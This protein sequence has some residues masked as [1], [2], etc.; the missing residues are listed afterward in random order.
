MSAAVRSVEL[1]PKQS[2][3]LVAKRKERNRTRCHPA[4]EE[5]DDGKGDGDVDE[6][7][8]GTQRLSARL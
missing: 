7:S 4:N 5:D 1:V 2:G 8:H 3:Q 6:L